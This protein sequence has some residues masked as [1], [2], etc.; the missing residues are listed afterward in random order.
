M[1]SFD[2]HRREGGK[3]RWKN[4]LKTRR[5]AIFQYFDGEKKKERNAAQRVNNTVCFRAPL[6]FD[7]FIRG[8]KAV[9]KGGLAERGETAGSFANSRV[10]SVATFYELSSRWLHDENCK[11]GR[12]PTIFIKFNGH[13]WKCEAQP[14]RTFF[15]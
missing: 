6:E 2:F 15:A 4:I 14:I 12:S 11:R 3:I 13:G 8:Y 7:W 10:E 5:F 9:R 1:Q